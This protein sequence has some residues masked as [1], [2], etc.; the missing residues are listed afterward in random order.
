MAICARIITDQLASPIQLLDVFSYTGGP[1]FLQPGIEVDLFEIASKEDIAKSALGGHLQ[2]L[3]G[4]GAV[5]VDDT[6]DTNAFQVSDSIFVTEYYTT[7]GNLANVRP[8][9]GDF[10]TRRLARKELI[11]KNSGTNSATIT[12]WGSID[13]GINYDIFILNSIVLTPDCILEVS[14][15]RAFTNIRIY[16]KSTSL[17]M[18]TIL[19]TRGY[20]I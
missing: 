15:D 3:I 13:N 2:Q 17:G 16:A 20:G 12:V 4:T 10:Q 14:E 1:V 11:I 9:N 19:Q 8:V 6:F 18:H 5:S 7:N